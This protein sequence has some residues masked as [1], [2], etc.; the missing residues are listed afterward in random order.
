MVVR[1]DTHGRTQIVHEKANIKPI[2]YD[3]MKEIQLMDVEQVISCKTNE[4]LIW[5]ITQIQDNTIPFA[6]GYNQIVVNRETIF[7]DSMAEILGLEDLR[8]VS[9]DSDLST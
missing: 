8:M 1:R 9:F 3:R 7:H 4:K 6:Q 2:Q 5:F